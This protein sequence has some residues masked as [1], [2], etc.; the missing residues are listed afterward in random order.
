[1]AIQ[2]AAWM[3]S[4]LYFAWFPIETIRG[5]H[6]TKE[7]AP[8]RSSDLPDLVPPWVAWSNVETELGGPVEEGEISL[9]SRERRRFL[10]A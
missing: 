3:A 10:I 5:E 8:L 9:L 2:I 4:G 1:M 7:P 6:L